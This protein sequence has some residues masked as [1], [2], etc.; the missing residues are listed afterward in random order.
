[1][2]L[3]KSDGPK[4]NECE[5]GARRR[6]VSALGPAMLRRTFSYSVSLLS[7]SAVVVTSMLASG[8][9]DEPGA[10]I[11]REKLA[12]DVAG[13]V[14]DAFAAC[15]CDSVAIGNAGECATAIQPALEQAIVTGEEIGLRYYA[16]CLDRT[17]ALLSA[18]GCGDGSLDE[19]G[20][21][22]A[23]DAGIC[24]LLAGDA[25]LGDACTSVGSL[26]FSGV[27]DTCKH[28]LV[29][30]AG[31]C[32]KWPDRQGSICEGIGVCPP[33]L[34]CT[35]PDADG[36][37]SCEPRAASGGACNPH[38]GPAGCEDDLFCSDVSQT[39]QALPGASQPCLLGQCASGHVCLENVCVVPPGNG[40]AC[41]DYV[42][43]EGLVCT[44]DMSGNPICATLPGEGQMC[45]N[46][47]GCAAGL[48]CEF[49]FCGEPPAAVCSV[50]GS[51]GLCIY[52]GDG[53]CD[54]PEGTGLC[55]EGTDPQD[56][57]CAT[58]LD[59][60]CDEPEGTGFCLEG[61]DPGDCENFCATQGNGVCD[62]PEAGN[63]CPEG[64]DVLD[65]GGATCPTAN[66]GTC[67]E[68]EGTAT[69]LEGTDPV[70][71]GATPCPYQGDSVCDEPEGTG[72]CEEGTDPND[73][74]AGTCPYQNDGQCDEPEGSNL[75]LEGTDP[76]DCQ[77]A[78]CP[79]QNDGVCDEYFETCAPGTD[80][81]DCQC[82]YAGDGI[83]NEPAPVG[84][85]LCAAGTDSL[86]CLG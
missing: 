77:V 71:C 46:G 24:K 8:C 59:G 40:E 39:C 55:Q 85:G 51:I 48:V 67:D 47:S 80:T 43:G 44:P 6:G 81:F 56:C 15:A 73:C 37:H 45:L 74:A 28:D 14:C 79:S 10:E 13:V 18:L 57:T 22:A 29:C 30:A 78:T 86:D 62:E 2:Q 49:G 7:L 66:D 69:C 53:L 70:D 9:K 41:P 76:D 65:C 75:C 63:T 60:I 84:D 61:T 25:G 72:L 68:P 12:K 3:D 4:K 32:V 82:F 23:F 54:E 1:M 16:E 17:E 52:Q 38:D 21:Q 35:D 20:A 83:C 11:D 34:S 19:A 33:G 26:G 27:G 36:V 58:E 64:S 42:C 31:I 5:A 50:P